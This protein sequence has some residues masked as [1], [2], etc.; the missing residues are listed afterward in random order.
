[1]HRLLTV[2]QPGLTKSTQTTIAVW[3][4]LG[5]TQIPVRCLPG[6]NWTQDDT[7]SS[8]VHS[9][10]KRRETSSWGYS[11]KQ[12]HGKTTNM[13]LYSLH[14]FCVAKV[15][16]LVLVVMKKILVRSN[17]ELSSIAWLVMTTRLMLRNYRTF[18]PPAWREVYI[19]LLPLMP[20]LDPL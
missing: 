17:F 16:S 18:W 6:L 3:P 9:N 2:R 5:A 10:Q 7:S 12:L 11:P 14:G 8:P 4:L 19:F 1:M 13:N 15:M 20:V